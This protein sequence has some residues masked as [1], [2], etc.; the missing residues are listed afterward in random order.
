MALEII[1]YG[2]GAA[3]NTIFESLAR[4]GNSSLMGDLIFLTFSV[5]YI[6]SIITQMAGNNLRQEI[7]RLFFALLFVGVMVMQSTT[8]VIR[9]ESVNQNKPID[10]VPL[11]VAL[12]G[13]FVSQVAD[14]TTRGLETLFSVPDDSFLGFRKGGVLFA[15]TIL[16][17]TSKAEIRNPRLERN[18]RAFTRQCI[19]P[20]VRIKARYTLEQLAAASDPWEFIKNNT[21][22]LRGI[23]YEGADSHIPQFM[24]CRA[25]AIA[26]DG[27]LRQEALTHHHK[28]AF[29]FTGSK[30]ERQ[31]DVAEQF[32]T[33]KIGL[34]RNAIAGELRVVHTDF[35]KMTGD[36]FSILKQHMVRNYLLNS[37]QKNAMVVN[38]PAAAQAYGIARAREVQSNNMFITGQLAPENLVYLYNVFQA[39]TYASFIIVI[40]LIPFNIGF[41]V[42]QKYIGLIVWI[43]SWPIIFAIINCIQTEAL[44]GVTSAAASFIDP[45]TGQPGVGWNLFTNLDILEANKRTALMTGSL[46][47]SVPVFALILVYGAGQAVHVASGWMKSMDAA[48][49]GGARDMTDGKVEGDSVNINN[50]SIGIDNRYKSNTF[51]EQRGGGMTMDLDS[52]SSV[53]QTRD[54]KSILSQHMS[55]TAAG[56]RMSDAVQASVQKQSMAAQSALAAN[57]EAYSE[58]LANTTATGIQLAINDGFNV[59]SGTHWGNSEAN[60]FSQAVGDAKKLTTQFARDNGLTEQQ[61]ASLLTS[62]ELSLRAGLPT[63]MIGGAIRAFGKKNSG[64]PA[65]SLE[66][67]GSVPTDGNTTTSDAITGVVANQSNVKPAGK[68]AKAGNIA[69][70]VLK[71]LIPE[72]NLTGKGGLDYKNISDATDKFSKAVNFYKENSLDK[73]FDIITRSSKDLNYNENNIRNKDLAN[74]HRQGL[75]NLARASKDL[76]VS[77]QRNKSISD[78]ANIVKTSGASVEHN[79]QQLLVDGISNMTDEFGNKLGTKVADSIL[80]DPVKSKPYIDKF[81]ESHVEDVEKIYGSNALSKGDLQKFYDGGKENMKNADVLQA[82]SAQSVNNIEEQAKAEGIGVDGSNISKEAVDLYEHNKEV[83]TTEIVEQGNTIANDGE[84]HENLVEKGRDQTD[85][86]LLN[87]S[88]SNFFNNI[89]GRDNKPGGQG[90]SS[91]E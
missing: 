84:R 73:K 3:L 10:N 6:H 25:A 12:I 87:R 36:S 75:E 62:A 45:S 83:I 33:A 37:A 60:S 16:R 69:K 41:S 9:D 35:T 63:N 81:L 50:R 14:H 29:R 72:V 17:E 39:L 1:T 34:V 19:I 55:N 67:V 32:S 51:G 18:F 22:P 61:A 65:S 52:G 76:N 70:G 23:N 26:L 8:V 2:G 89:G 71:A 7:I 58:A 77:M 47:S 80:S 46:V 54:G 30:G 91:N 49:E 28:L 85:K 78:L 31:G 11:G 79:L 88:A 24:V 64:V 15:S 53:T 59:S 21:S 38:A 57:Q 4:F 86:G 40:L 66:G 13:S 56:V 48:G 90:G 5:A 43:H 44:Y 20:D 27:D 82:E 68:L 42:F 74:T